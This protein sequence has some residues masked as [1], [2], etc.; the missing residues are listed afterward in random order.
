LPAKEKVLSPE[1][2][3]EITV[4]HDSSKELKIKARRSQGEKPSLPWRQVMIARALHRSAKS[5][6]LT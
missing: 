6:I 5:R 4:V 2:I 1:W 3:P